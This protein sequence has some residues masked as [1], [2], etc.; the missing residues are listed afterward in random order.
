MKNEKKNKNKLEFTEM[1]TITFEEV[2]NFNPIK[3]DKNKFHVN[4]KGMEQNGDM[5]ICMAAY[6][7]EISKYNDKKKEFY[8]LQ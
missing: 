5:E 6:E 3:S 7:T 4:E 1:D 8:E 2:E